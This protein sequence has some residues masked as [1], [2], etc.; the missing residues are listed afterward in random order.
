MELLL[1]VV[2]AAVVV[3]PAVAVVA[4]AVLPVVAEPM[5]AVTALQVRKPHAPE[6][7]ANIKE[8]IFLPEAKPLKVLPHRLSTTRAIRAAVIL[9][10]AIPTLRT[11]I[12]ALNQVMIIKTKIPLKSGIF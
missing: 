10:V 3:L 8:M 12:K 9:V 5:Q 2:A 6:T 4:H 7:V 1:K 11:Q